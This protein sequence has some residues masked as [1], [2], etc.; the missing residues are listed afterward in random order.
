MT[1]AIDLVRLAPWDRG[2][3]DPD[4]ALA[5]A[6]RVLPGVVAW[7]GEFTGSFW[8]LHGGRL[9]EFADGWALLARVRAIAASMRASR[10]PRRRDVPSGAVPPPSRRR[11]P[12]P[13]FLPPS[14]F[15]RF[16]RRLAALLGSVD[17]GH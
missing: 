10:V 5:E 4:V 1:A 13:F 16:T 6:R 12:E 2:P 3:I 15:R 17:A 7:A 11:P 14:R 8:L 9:E